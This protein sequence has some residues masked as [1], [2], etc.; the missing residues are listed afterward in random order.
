MHDIFRIR[1]AT[2]QDADVIAWHRARMFQD[3][4]DVS[5]DGFEILRA[6]ARLRLK[7]WL[8]SGDYIGWLATP[9][10]K[11]ETVVGGAGIQLQPILPRPRDASTIGEGRQGTIVNVFTEPQWRRRGVAGGLL[12]EIIAWS[13]NEG[14]DRL[15]LHASDDGRS[16]YERL[17]FIAGNEMYFAGVS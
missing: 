15:L 10:D 12:N 7:E 3:M 4:G 1:R 14:L 11:P 9:A 16:V 2:V 6:K 8:E 17:G 13:K 5:D